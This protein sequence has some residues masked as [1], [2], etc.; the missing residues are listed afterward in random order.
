MV[1]LDLVLLCF[2]Q[3]H[4]LFSEF[5]TKEEGAYCFACY[6]CALMSVYMFVCTNTSDEHNFIEKSIGY[7]IVDK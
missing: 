5:L 3:C 2:S 4:F 7:C 1:C 6:S